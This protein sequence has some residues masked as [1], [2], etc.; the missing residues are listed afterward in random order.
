MS[1]GDVAHSEL[2]QVLDPTV[3]Y[4]GG[5][6]RSGSTLLECLLAEVDGTVALGE[7]VHLWER[8]LKQDQ[9]CACGANFHACDFWREIGSVAFGGWS[10]VDLDRVRFLAGAVDRQRWIPQS[11]RRSP[12]PEFAALA[13]EYASYYQR[14]YRAAATI[15]GARVV[16]DSSKEIPTALA[17]SHLVDLDLRVLHIVRDAR[18]VA[19]SWSKVVERPEADG[20]PMPRFSPARSTTFWLSGNLTVAALRHRGVP[21]ARL[22]YEDLV[23]APVPT[24]RAAW[25]R[26]GVP[27]QLDVPMVDDTAI[28]LGATHSVAGNPMRFRRGLTRLR[29][30]EAWRTALPERDRRVVT[31]MAWPVLKSFGYLEANR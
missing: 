12:S 8:G 15:T 18:G 31:A 20:E 14:I 27:L 21:V 7:V 17:L 28:E 24:I 2:D 16:I 4:V 26:L 1:T 5:W 13:V 23:E 25:E 22:R 10:A 19:Y 9:L 30:D 29:A 11:G 6:G 3:L